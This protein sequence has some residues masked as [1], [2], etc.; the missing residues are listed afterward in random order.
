MH[1]SVFVYLGVRV[2]LSP[3]GQIYLYLIIT[4]QWERLELKKVVFMILCVRIIIQVNNLSG[5]KPHN[6]R[7]QEKNNYPFY[8]SHRSNPGCSFRD[9]HFRLWLHHPL[10]GLL[11]DHSLS[12]R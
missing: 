8:S 10:W 6:R 3:Q 11:S 2:T 1:I 5:F 12:G 7:S 9:S 4:R